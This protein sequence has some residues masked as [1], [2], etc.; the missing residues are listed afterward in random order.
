MYLGALTLRGIAS[1]WFFCF[2]LWAGSVNALGSDVCVCIVEESLHL[3]ARKTNLDSTG[4]VKCCL[5]SHVI[6]ISGEWEEKISRRSVWFIIFQILTKEKVNWNVIS[7]QQ[8]RDKFFMLLSSSSLPFF[9]F[10]S[11]FRVVWIH[12]KGANDPL[13]AKNSDFPFDAEISS[14]VGSCWYCDDASQAW[15]SLFLTHDRQC[16]YLNTGSGNFSFSWALC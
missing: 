5:P 2:V 1:F 16:L 13:P 10:W 14:T 12:L 7:Q 8:R 3:V 15:W 4:A 6:A 9:Q 11:K